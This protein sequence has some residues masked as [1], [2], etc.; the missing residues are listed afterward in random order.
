VSRA[1]LVANVLAVLASRTAIVLPYLSSSQQPEGERRKK[2]KR[3]GWRRRNWAAWIRGEEEK[4]KRGVGR[5][6]KEEALGRLTWERK[7]K[8]HRVGLASRKEETEGREERA[9]QAYPWPGPFRFYFTIIIFLKK[10]I[11]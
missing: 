9:E 2:R 6:W 10:I 3:L 11:I 8:K 1:T 4:N 7:M 5:A